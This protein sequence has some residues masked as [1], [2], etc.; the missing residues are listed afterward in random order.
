MTTMFNVLYAINALVFV[1]LMILITSLVHFQNPFSTVV[2][3]EGF[4]TCR[5]V[6]YNNSSADV[7]QA[8]CYKNKIPPHI[9]KQSY[10][11]CTCVSDP[12]KLAYDYNVLEKQ[13]PEFAGV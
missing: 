1:F 5:G 8:N 12:G 4:C 11:G 3:K 6:Q 2:E 7:N 13:L 10:G 9:L